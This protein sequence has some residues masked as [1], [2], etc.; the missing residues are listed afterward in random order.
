MFLTD[1]TQ[2]CLYQVLVF[3]LILVPLQVIAIVMDLFTDID[4]FKDL[5]DASYKRKVSVYIMLETTGVKHFLRMCEKAG[6]HTGHLKACHNEYF[7]LIWVGLRWD[8]NE[9]FAEKKHQIIKSLQFNEQEQL[10][11]R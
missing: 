5:L 3:S 1:I 9:L 10:T 2:F 7:K 6:M 11:E 8:I 4:I